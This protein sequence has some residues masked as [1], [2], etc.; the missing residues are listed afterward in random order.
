MIYLPKDYDNLESFFSSLGQVEDCSEVNCLVGEQSDMLSG[1]NIASKSC[2]QE[3]ETDSLM[4]P[5]FSEIL[6]D[7]LKE[8]MRKSTLD[9]S[10]LSVQ[11]SPASRSQSQGNSMAP[12][13][14]ETNGQIPYEPFAWYDRDTS[15]WR[16][17][18]GCFR[19]ILV[20][21]EQYSETWPKAGILFDGTAYQLPSL[22]HPTKETGSGLWRSPASRDGEGG[23]MEMGEGKSGHYKLRDHVQEI[24]Q[25]V[26]PTLGTMAKYNLW[27]TPRAG[28]PGSRKPGTGGKVLAEEVK[29]WPTPTS[30]TRDGITSGGHSGLAGGSG[31]RQKL[32]KMLGKE[33]GKKMGSQALNPDWA[34]WLMGFPIGW[35]N[36]EPFTNIC[37]IEED[38]FGFWLQHQDDWWSVDPA[39]AKYIPRV[40]PQ[41]SNRVNRLKA[42][43]NGQV[44]QCMAFAWLNLQ[45]IN[46]SESRAIR[47]VKVKHTQSTEPKSTQ[48]DL[49]NF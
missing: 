46:W 24:N 25:H 15:S 10:M 7:S 34:E 2:K 48:Q 32:Y 16:T 44:P 21:S 4:M 1:T 20:I 39:D 22:V 9:M 27:P 8:D 3:L 49:F 37:F 42:L 11:A 30:C 18:L 43:G 6:K 35:S 5:Q 31:N 38:G 45:I 28:N 19:E 23:V 33:E 13:I 36:I 47:H 14:L 41:K 29:K 12:A 17:C 26:W 40:T